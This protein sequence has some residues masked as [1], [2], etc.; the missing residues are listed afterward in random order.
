MTVRLKIVIVLTLVLLTGCRVDA[1]LDARSPYYRVPVGSR[2]TLNQEL[3]VPGGRTRIF[4]QHGQ[5][6]SNGFDQYHPHCNFEI[7]TLSADVRT[8]APGDFQV[9]RVNWGIKEIVKLDSIMVASIAISSSGYSG[10][11]VTHY[12]DHY[13]SSTVQPDVMSL[14]CHGAFDDPPYADPPT[15]AEIREALGQIAT[16]HLKN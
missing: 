6:L 5:T 2:I 8:I 9:V 13:L 7:R 15:I 4:L 1:V 16:L 11:M 3:K 12:V 10:S 14:A